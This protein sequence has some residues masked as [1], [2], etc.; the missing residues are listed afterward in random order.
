L[1]SK[2]LLASLRRPSPVLL[3]SE[4]LH[5]LC[6]AAEIVREENTALAGM[7]RVFDLDGDYFVQEETPDRAVLVRPRPSLDEAMAFL[8]RR[9]QTY[10]RMWDG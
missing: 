9:L 3:S 2:E 6:E 10:E 8:D 7:I 1:T 5:A 4:G